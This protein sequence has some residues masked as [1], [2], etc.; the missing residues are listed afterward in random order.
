MT[1]HVLFITGGSRGIGAGIV[2]A[3]AAAGF[4]VAF[5]Y[6]E[7]EDAAAA[8]VD[9]VRAESPA[10]RC[11]AYMLDVRDS[12]AVERVGD[13]VLE[14][15]G[16]VHV[17][18]ANAAITH[19]SLAF[20]TTDEVW[21]DVIDTNLTG[22][23]FV[24]RQFLP[25]FLANGFG[26]FIF[27]SSI[28]AGGMTGGAAYSASKAGLLGLS[29]A[30]AKEYGRKGITSNAL[31]L[32]FFETDMTLQQVSAQNLEFYRRY[33]PLGRVGTLPEVAAAVLFLASEGASFVNGQDIGVTGGLEWLN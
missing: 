12:T 31:Q 30:L 16:T 5:T 19:A 21:R 15:F 1:R 32:S 4:D 13:R 27:I 29:G 6:R 26:R 2:R 23:F 9:A 7:R 8:V 14:D 33:S 28:A 25:A 11:H 17:V 10:A 18:V 24:A 22:S 3:A 20:S